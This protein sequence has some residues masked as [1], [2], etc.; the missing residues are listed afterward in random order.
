MKMCTVGPVLVKWAG[1]ETEYDV[2]F[3]L[4]VVSENR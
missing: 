3:A 2:E 4:G 1:R